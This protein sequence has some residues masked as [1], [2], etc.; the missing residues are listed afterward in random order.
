MKK[1]KGDKE[2]KGRWRMVGGMKNVRGYEERE[3]A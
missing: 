1:G 2:R 3:G